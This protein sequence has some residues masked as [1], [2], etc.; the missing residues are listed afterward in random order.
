M[1]DD[2]THARPTASS[3]PD[4]H[5][6]IPR[7]RELR[8]ES[9]SAPAELQPAELQPAETHPVDGSPTSSAETAAPSPEVQSDVI[10]PRPCERQPQ[11]GSR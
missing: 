1:Q 8:P 11:A 10:E 4:R 6:E 2:Q 7:V 3:D 9:R 5:F